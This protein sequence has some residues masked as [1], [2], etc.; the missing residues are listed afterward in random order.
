MHRPRL[1]NV[2]RRDF[3]RASAAAGLAVTSTFL[4]Q[5]LLRA[6]E[7]ETEASGG[8]KREGPC[9]RVIF[10]FME[11]GPSQLETF[12][13]KPG[14]PHA[15]PWKALKTE[16]PGFT[17]VEHLPKIASLA[18]DLCLIRSM[19]SGSVDHQHARYLMHT[20]WDSNPTMI[21]PGMGSIVS[22]QMGQ[23]DF[24]LPNFVK[25]GGGPFSA[26]YLGAEHNPF[27]IARAGADIANLDYGMG[28]NK[29]RADRRGAIMRKLNDRFAEEHGEEAVRAREAAMEKARRLMDSPLRKTFDLAD[30][31]ESVTKAYGDGDF[32]KGCIL[33]RR[34]IEVG[35]PA[36]EVNLGGW[37]THDD[38]F[39]KNLVN[40]QTLDQPYHALITDL[41]QRGLLE[42]TL[43]VW[44]GEFGR[45]PQLSNTQGRGH[46]SK[47]FCCLLAGGGVKTGQVVGET[48][49]TGEEL[50]SDPIAPHDLYATF[51]KLM[52]WDVE[53]KFLAG[54]RPA[55]LVNKVGVPLDQ[56]IE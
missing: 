34:L 24:D 20:G 16:V 14:Q 38:A 23:A 40:C 8:E 3:L 6:Q 42:S 32:A 27:V 55:Y 11:G 49:E 53:K 52:G 50:A 46:W 12:D 25:I 45:A 48:S 31:P 44:M 7:G 30:E 43:V 35:V 54:E 56:L 5:N 10:L 2:S 21:R 28:N 13:P 9:K 1:S 17:V 18:G 47:N 4:F 36:V 26:G 37:D 51:G 19:R 15:A 22:H 39:N 41:R 33:A 29:E